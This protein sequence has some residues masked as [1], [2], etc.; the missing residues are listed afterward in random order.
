MMVLF[1]GLPKSETGKFDRR[2][3]IIIFDVLSG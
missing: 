3:N 2:S 1:F